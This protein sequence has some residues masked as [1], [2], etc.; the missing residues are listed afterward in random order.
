MVASAAQAVLVNPGWCRGAPAVSVLQLSQEDSQAASR[1][2]LQAFAA[3][4]IKRLCP[5]GFVFLWVEKQYLHG[6]VKQMGKWDFAY[7]ENLTWVQA[8]PPAL[9]AP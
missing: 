8:R 2:V 5:V 9:T 6:I 1:K 3:L 4:P 7:I